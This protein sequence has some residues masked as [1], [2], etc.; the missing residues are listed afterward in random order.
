MTTRDR[1]SLAVAALAVVVAV[2]AMKLG[3]P[4]ILVG[5][6]IVWAICA[7]V[8]LVAGLLVVLA[9]GGLVGGWLTIDEDNDEVTS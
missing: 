9:N 8:V 7:A 1:I 2:A 6:S 3:V 4:R 5:I